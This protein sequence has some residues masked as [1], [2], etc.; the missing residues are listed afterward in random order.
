VRH[1]LRG[2]KTGREFRLG[3]RVRVK[4]VR[5]DADALKIDLALIE[6]PTAAH[7]ATH[8]PVYDNAASAPLLEKALRGKAAADT[9]K[10]APAKKAVRKKV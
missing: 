6:T 7:P 3:Q 1:V 8:E 10:T 9:S 2:E 5:A 4:I